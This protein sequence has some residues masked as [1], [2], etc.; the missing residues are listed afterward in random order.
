MQVEQYK[1]ICNYFLT[2]EQD[3]SNTSKFVEHCEDN[4][5]TYS[6]EFYKIIQLSCAEIDSVLK[7]LCKLWNV[8]VETKNIKDYAKIIIPNYYQLHNFSTRMI[9]S[10][11][12]LI[13]VPWKEW[14]LDRAP[15][16]WRDYQRL[17]HNHTDNFHLAT[18]ENA[19]LSLSALMITIHMIKLTFS[20][21][22]LDSYMMLTQK[23]SIDYICD[24][25]PRK[26]E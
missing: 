12:P 7:E 23:L 10:S 8:D 9:F 1:N 20:P 19:Y 16:W 26:L 18:L 25:T 22:E 2:L 21:G 3:L 17:K 11:T 15:L 6:F 5:K 14:T 13:F 24:V 4:F